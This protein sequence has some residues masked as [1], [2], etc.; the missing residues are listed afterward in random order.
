MEIGAST[1]NFY[2]EPL[3]DA[4]DRVLAAG[5]RNVEIF[6]NAPSE[7]TPAFVSE[8][9][10]RVDDAGAVVSA[11]HPYSSFMEPFF[12]FSP[13][14]RRVTDGFAMY[15]PMFEAAAMLGAPLLVLHGAKDLGQLSR[16]Q[17]VGRYEALYRLGAS[18]GVHT[19]QENVVKFCSEDPAYLQELQALMGDR[20]RFVFDFKQT[21]RCGLDPAHVMDVMGGN[22]AHVHISDRDGTRDCLPPGQGEREYLPLLRRLKSLGYDGVLMM[23]LYRQNFGDA[24]DLIRAREFLKEITCLL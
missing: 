24:N 3:E 14:E 22:I 1:S 18:Y 19:A 15:E 7:V 6:F 4:L 21:G 17:L 10:K 16:A 23:E 9:K 2:P 5:F 20:M 12:L 13:Y 11:V 8:L